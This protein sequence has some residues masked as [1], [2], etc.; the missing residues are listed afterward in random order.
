MDKDFLNSLNIFRNLNPEELDQ[1]ITCLY[2]REVE[3]N[4]MLFS[5]L[6]KEQV[7]YI[8]REGKLNLDLPGNQEK[9]YKPGDVF[10]EIAMVSNNFRSGTI[11]AVEKSLL[12]GLRKQD[13]INPEKVRAGTSLKVFIELAGMISSYLVSVQNTTTHRLIELGENEFVE[14]KSTLRKNLF[15]KKFDKAIEHAS[16]KTIAAFL[17]TS[18]GTL[19]V[20]VDDK[21]N[22][23]GLDNDQFENDDRMLLHLNQMIQERIGTMHSRYI[24][25]GIEE[26]DSNKLLRIDVR[27]ADTPAYLTYK[28]EEYFFIRSGPST[29]SIKVSEIYDYVRTRFYPKMQ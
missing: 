19:L 9:C 5:R 14:F 26:T 17:N 8:V 28:G 10:G 1:V 15:T 23:L 27:P 7:L 18:G 20:G 22:M 29:S 13:L 16:L 2:K 3:A 6:E 24:L 12:Y 21:R 25:S 11:T 4:E